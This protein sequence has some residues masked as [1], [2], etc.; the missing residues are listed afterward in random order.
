[1]KKGGGREM[2]VLTMEKKE[3]RQWSLP[4][5]KFEGKKGVP[6]Q[7]T[8]LRLWGEWAGSKGKRST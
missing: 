7:M 4:F 5:V 3:S 8:V 1:V 2:K 6:A